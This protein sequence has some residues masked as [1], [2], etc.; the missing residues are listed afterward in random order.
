MPLE[1]FATDI[2][3]AHMPELRFLGLQ[4]GSRM[5]V[6]R[7]PDGGLWVHSPIAMTPELRREVD[8]LGPVR[9]IVAPNV[10]H[11]LYAGDWARLYPDAQLWGAQG[12]EKKRKDLRFHGILGRDGPAW[13]FRSQHIAGSFLDETMFFHEP[14]GTLISCDLF[15]NLHKCDHGPTRV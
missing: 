7:L 5:T 2:W 13:P 11:H 14:S 8:E 6:V 4:V 3:T 15:E 12:L 9:W 1:P 10:Y